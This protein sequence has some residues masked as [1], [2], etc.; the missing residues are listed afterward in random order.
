MPVKLDDQQARAGALAAWRLRPEAE[1]PVPDTL[2]SDR[3]S[4]AHARLRH[5][6]RH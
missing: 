6:G 2:F 3:A 4:E 1:M 5:R